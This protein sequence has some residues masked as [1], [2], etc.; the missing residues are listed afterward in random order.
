MITR[1][2]KVKLF[3][4]RIKKLI[5]SFFL[6]KLGFDFQWLFLLYFFMVRKHSINQHENTQNFKCKGLANNCD[7]CK[8]W[9]RNVSFQSQDDPL[10]HCVL[11]C[12][13]VL[14]TRL[15]TSNHND[16]YFKYFSSNRLEIWENHFSNV[17]CGLQKGSTSKYGLS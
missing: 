17:S 4:C 3:Q 12:L 7:T 9:S 13:G 6:R 2:K 10:F 15:C 11:L 16:Q 1:P 8:C 5:L 14:C